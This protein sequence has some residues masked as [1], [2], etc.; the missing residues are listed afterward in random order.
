MTFELLAIFFRVITDK[1]TPV[2]VLG[3]VVGE[4]L[5]YTTKAETDC[6]QIKNF[7]SNSVM[8]GSNLE[9]S[10]D[11]TTVEHGKNGIL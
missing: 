10:H 7:C 3:N 5:N 11:R 4:S 9:E 2:L 1:P 6:V 8:H